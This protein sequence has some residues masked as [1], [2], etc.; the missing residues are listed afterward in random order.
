MPLTDVAERAGVGIATLYRRF[1]TRSS[2]VEGAFEAAFARYDESADAALAEEDPWEGFAGLLE[3]M[4]ALQAENRGF[5]HLVQSSVPLGHRRDGRR[6]R[7]YRKVVDVIDRARRA[8]AIRE[9]ISPEDL[10]V[11]SFALAGILE[12]TRDDQPDA[13]RR[14]LA[15]ALQGCRPDAAASLPPAPVPRQ[16]QRAMLRSGRRRQQRGQRCLPLYAGAWLAS[17]TSLLSP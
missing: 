16:L 12:V 15:L 9:D 7:A 10:P 6:E 2:L 13:W 17:L 5:T 3:R 8:G 4:G 11:L 14:H 1:P